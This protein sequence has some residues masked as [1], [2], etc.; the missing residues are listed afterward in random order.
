MALDP[1]TYTLSIFAGQRD[2][3]LSDIYAYDFAS[4]TVSELFNNL[5]ASGG[6]YA[7]FTQR[8]VVDPE[9][10]EVYVCARLYPCL[11]AVVGR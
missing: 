10:I 5:S 3:Y 7:C 8:A 2:K 1:H 6:P 4:D 9:L 11:R